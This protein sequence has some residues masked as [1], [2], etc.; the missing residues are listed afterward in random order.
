GLILD[1]LSFI[2]SALYLRRI[3]VTEP[4]KRTV[5]RPKTKMLQELRVAVRFI[6]KDAYMRVITLN[7]TAVNFC[8]GGVQALTLIYLV[9]VVGLGDWSYGGVIVAISVGGVLG[10]VLSPMPS[11]KMGAAP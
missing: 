5:D 6:F 11:A 8:L 9:Q 2:V 7:V 3:S 4:P 10:A 1:S